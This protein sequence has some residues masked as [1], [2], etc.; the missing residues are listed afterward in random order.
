MYTMSVDGVIFY[1]D[2]APIEELKVISPTLKLSANNAGSLEMTIPL[3]NIAYNLIQRMRSEIIVYKNGVEIWSGRVLSESLDFYNQ[4]K[5]TLEGELAYLNDTTQPQR[6]YGEVTLYQFLESVLAI[7]NSKVIR[8]NRKFYL[9][10][11]NLP[12]VGTLEYRATDYEKTLE[13]LNHVI[14]D[15][16]GYIKILKKEGKRY[17]RIEP[18]VTDVCSQTIRFGENLIDFTADYDMTEVCSVLLPLGAKEGEEGGASI[19]DELTPTTVHEHSVLDMSD[20]GKGS[21]KDFSNGYRVAE[22][23]VAENKTYYVTSRMFQGFGLWV[24]RDASGNALDSKS[25]D[26]KNGSTDLIETAVEMKPGAVKLLVGGFGGDLPIRV[27]ESVE[28]QGSLE[29]YTTVESVNNGSLYV[30]TQPNNLLKTDFENGSIDI[31]TG[32]NMDTPDTNTLLCRTVSPVGL[33]AGDY[34][35]SAQYTEAIGT[36]LKATIYK[37]SLDGKFIGLVGNAHQSMPLQ[38]KLDDSVALRFVFAR[39]DLQAVTTYDIWNSEVELNAGTEEQEYDSPYSLLDRYD[40]IEKQ[41]TWEDVTDPAVLMQYAQEYLKSGQFDEMTI[42]VT[43]LDLSTMGVDIDSVWLLTSIH[44][45]SYPHGL[46]KWFD[47]TELEIPLAEPQNATFHLGYSTEQTLTGINNEVNEDLVKRI[48]EVPSMPSVLQSVLTNAGNIVKNATGGFITLEQTEDGNGI[49][50]ILGSTKPLTNPPDWSDPNQIDAKGFIFNDQGLA[51]FGNGFN[52]PATATIVGANG[53]IAGENIVAG[54]VTCDKI[55]GN[56][57]KLGGIGN[58]NGDIAVVDESDKN[59]FKLGIDGFESHF[60]P[61]DT[62][63]RWITME[64]GCLRG[65]KGD[66]VVGDSD[67]SYGGTIF[68]GS[69][70]E[71]YGTGI[72]IVSPRRIVMDAGKNFDL[73]AS[74]SGGD[75][76]FAANHEISIVSPRLY[77]QNSSDHGYGAHGH[78]DL[79]DGTSFD[80]LNGILTGYTRGGQTSGYSGRFSTGMHEGKYVTVE[81]NNGV[82]TGV[83]MQDEWAG[84]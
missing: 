34:I 5:L 41:I 39:E 68:L 40:W 28:K 13:T 64:D 16:G 71:G 32:N 61:Q 81:V 20:A 55:R 8:E 33:I 47:V 27:N 62:T 30:T 59:L 9:D 60:Y 48:G 43:A 66:D 67:D 65:G 58:E 52:Q 7:H 21:I 77:V 37:Y 26:N 23:D 17:L 3:T 78:I 29:Q 79:A 72:Y 76:R 74:E 42:D 19:G 56:T 57:L 11:V 18:Y 70:W 15:Y 51:Y 83:S 6:E 80:F 1:N 49:R 82:I 45:V 14:E 54:S 25:A 53:E 63:H 35:L 69:S 50:Q 31:S 46:D 10:S 2:K 44:V 24:M 73:S 22:F 38:F 84:P 36:N 75:I 12:D 4:R